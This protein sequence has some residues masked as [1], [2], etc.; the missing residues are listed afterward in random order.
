MMWNNPCLYHDLLDARWITRPAIRRHPSGDWMTS[1]AQAS[2]SVKMRAGLETE[3][4]GLYIPSKM[5]TDLASIPLPV[6][7]FFW[8]LLFLLGMTRLQILGEGV[9]HDWLYLAAP[10][11]VWGAMER[12]HADRI[13]LLLLLWRARN[14][15]QYGASRWT[16]PRVRWTLGAWLLYGAVRLGGRRS[17]DACRLLGK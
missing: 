8:P 15:R 10:T 12:I 1:D 3:E 17:W 2:F 9:A 6:R 14:W 16:A 13:F 7:M 4:C 11:M 5:K